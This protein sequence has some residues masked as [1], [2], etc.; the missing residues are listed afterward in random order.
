MSPMRV[1]DA[2]AAN[3]AA[4][5]QHSYLCWRSVSKSI[6]MVFGWNSGDWRAASIAVANMFM[7]GPAGLRRRCSSPD[8]GAYTLHV[9][10][11]RRAPRGNAAV[12]AASPSCKPGIN[13]KLF[14]G[15]SPEC[16]VNSM[17]SARPPAFQAGLMS[18]AA[19]LFRESGARLFPFGP[20]LWGAMSVNLFCQEIAPQSQIRVLAG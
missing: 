11:D 7:M 17:F 3:D 19:P 10:H 2:G 4:Q 15:L 16:G 5:R 20:S 12:P 6:P 9:R 14:G 18:G 13:G 1:I 8:S